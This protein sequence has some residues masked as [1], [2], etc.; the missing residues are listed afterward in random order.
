[1]LLEMPLSPLAT[2][3]GRDQ[4]GP[5]EAGNQESTNYLIE[6]YYTIHSIAHKEAFWLG[7]ICLEY[8]IGKGSVGNLRLSEYLRI[9]SALST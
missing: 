8:E 7:E 4:S 9:N 1:M 6:C 3:L 5:Y 2:T